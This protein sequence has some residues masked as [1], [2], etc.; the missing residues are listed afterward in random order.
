MRLRY[1]V[2]A[3]ALVSSAVTWAT[4]QVF[5]QQPLI[6]EPSVTGADIGFRVDSVKGGIPSGRIVI[7]VKGVWREADIAPPM[8]RTIPLSE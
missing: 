3:V 2:L 5:E 1:I 4:A 6:N 8:G 7:R